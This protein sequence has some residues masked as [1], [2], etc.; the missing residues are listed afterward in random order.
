MKNLNTLKINKLF[1]Q[2]DLGELIKEPKAVIGGLLHK[3]Y[4]VETKDHIYAVKALNPLHE[5]R[6]CL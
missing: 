6:T 3:M 1:V 4:K 5:K 2:L